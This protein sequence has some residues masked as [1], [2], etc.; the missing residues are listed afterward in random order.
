MSEFDFTEPEQNHGLRDFYDPQTF[1][2]FLHIQK[3][4]GMTLQ[5]YM[6]K[7]FGPSAIRRLV[8]RLREDRRL[9]PDII[10]AATARTDRDRFF[11]GHFCFG[12]H[13][14]LPK[15]A[16]YMT[17]LRDPVSR[18]VSLYRYSR[19]NPFAYYHREASENDLK[20]FVQDARLHELDNGMVRFI[21][22]A[23]DDHFINRTPF[24]ECNDE[25]FEKAKSNLDRFFFFVGIQE[26]FDQ[27]ML[28]F[29]NLIGDNSP[30]YLSLNRGKAIL[31]NNIDSGLERIIRFQNKYDEELYRV[32]R[33]KLAERLKS[34]FD[35]LDHDL[36][37]LRE[38]NRRYSHLMAIQKPIVDVLRLGA[39]KFLR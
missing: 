1:L 16:S 27:S 9:S 32:A 29:S 11:V 12:M 37:I 8:W 2:I 38:R 6:R 30:R 35:H 26:Q 19:N 23:T 24:G 3:T 21:A 4:A 31:N 15:P 14:H 34:K 13:R 17:F 5:R 25:I 10:E 28:L 7:Q 18:C 20:G 33:Q 36:E 39:Q 22:G